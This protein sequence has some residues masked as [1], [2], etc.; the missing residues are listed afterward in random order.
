[1]K[2][3][4]L[5]ENEK[6][7]VLIG[8]IDTWRDESKILEKSDSIVIAKIPFDPPTDPH[9][10]AKTIGMNNSFEIYSKPIVL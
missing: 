8:L 9:F 7:S 4:F 2:H 3:Y 1:M 5:K 10:L 6:K